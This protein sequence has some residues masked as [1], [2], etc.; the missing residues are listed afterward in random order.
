MERRTKL[1]PYGEQIDDQFD[2]ID[3]QFDEDASISRFMSYQSPSAAKKRGFP[4]EEGMPIFL[5]NPDELEQPRFGRAWY[6]IAIS[7][8]IR[9]VSI[10]AV[11]AA[12]IAAAITSM[13]NPL[14]LFANAKA[15]LVGTS[16]GPSAAIQSAAIQMRAAPEPVVVVRS[17]SNEPP[18]RETQPPFGAR[19]ALPPTPKSAPTRDEIAAAFKAARQGQADE[20]RQPL[21]AAPTVI[22]T[23]PA[24]AVA[25][26][27]AVAPAA[28]APAAIAP[29]VRRLDPDELAAL[30]KRAK[31][32]IAVGD[33]AP[34]R[35]LLERAA[36]AQEATAALLLAQ[37]YDPAV[38]GK[39]DMRSVTPDSAKAREWYQKAARFG[40]VDAQQRLSQM[41]K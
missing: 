14:A 41:Q 26:P 32:L 9:K 37:T 30:L 22:A 21:A 36:D 11:S 23:A 40:S 29:S 15:S 34:A 12:A 19:A 33:I 8:H 17:A 27:N 38:L 6:R 1:P 24:N 13:E 10:L 4:G 31:G 7:K 2:E 3:N 16:A 20:V 25:P 5:S 18:A 39:Q 28:A 35:L